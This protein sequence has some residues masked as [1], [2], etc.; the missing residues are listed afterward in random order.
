[1]V[2]DYLNRFQ[3]SFHIATGGS[4]INKKAGAVRYIREL[5]YSFSMWLSDCTLIFEAE[6]MATSIALHNFP[7]KYN[8]VIITTHCR[9]VCD[10]LD[11]V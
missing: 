9:A 11:R 3:D 1:M 6:M 5:G 4:D 2:P 7:A 10:T 8:K